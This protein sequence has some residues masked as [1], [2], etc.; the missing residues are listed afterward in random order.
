MP[1]WLARIRACDKRRHPPWHPL[2]KE[3]LA[4]DPPP[5]TP[6]PREKHLSQAGSL[7]PPALT[8]APRAD[9][10]SRG[11][12]LDILERAKTRPTWGYAPPLPSRE[13]PMTRSE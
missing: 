5:W 7:R 8:R 13:Y 10:R 2:T 9:N 12:Q 1:G 6:R 4:A 3:P 11:R